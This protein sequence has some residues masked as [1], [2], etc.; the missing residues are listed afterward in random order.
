MIHT[1]IYHPQFFTA[2]IIG[3]KNLLKEE[4][5]KLIIIEALAYL[6]K[7]KVII[8]GFVIMDNHVHLI[9]QFQNENTR[10][11]VQHS[12]LSYTAKQFKRILQNENQNFLNEFMV[13]AKDRK[14]QFWQRDS[15]SIDLFTPKVF[16]QKLEYI[17]QNPVKASI[18]KY[19]EDYRF[20]SA[21]F[22]FNEQDEFNFLSHYNG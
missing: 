6:S 20:S 11:K 3:W 12:F 4:Q 8:Y 22:Y 2:T 7:E 13:N 16:K 21:K 19:P 14:F 10:E 15:L 18:C 1:S 5:F 17:H 9:W